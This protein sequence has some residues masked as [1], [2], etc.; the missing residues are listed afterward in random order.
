M[1]LV[2]WLSES[3]ER[4]MKLLIICLFFGIICANVEEKP[5]VSNDELVK[6]FEDLKSEFDDLKQNNK[7]M[8]R[9][10][11]LKNEIKKL[12][13]SMSNQDERIQANEEDLKEVNNLKTKVEHQEARI[14]AN[15]EDL[16]E[17]DSL[18]TKV[19][20]QEA[21]I[22]ANEEGLKVVDDLKTNVENQ[23]A[24]IK[25]NEDGLD[26]SICYLIDKL[27]NWDKDAF[28]L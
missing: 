13:A 15:K 28:L 26:V 20:N 17:V 16:K 19:K 8:G 3:K 22:Q 11:E 18:K 10:S 2:D 1:T 27:Q 6:M 21:T 5:S 9:F 24:R 25:A 4:N 23:A 7:K 12:N 14:L